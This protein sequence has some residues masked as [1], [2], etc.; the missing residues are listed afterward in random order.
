MG[1]ICF[2]SRKVPREEA[3]AETLGAASRVLLSEPNA[4]L[5]PLGSLQQWPAPVLPAPRASVSGG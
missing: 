5:P 4:G 3:E 1:R 2:E